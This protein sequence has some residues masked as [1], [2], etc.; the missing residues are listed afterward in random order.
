MSAAVS[1]SSQ[2]MARSVGPGRIRA[3]LRCV[4]CEVLLEE[5]AR[6]DAGR[7]HGGID[8]KCRAPR[9]PGAAVHAD[10]CELTVAGLEAKPI[11]ARVAGRGLDPCE[12]CIRDPAAT[13]RRSDVHALDLGEVS[14]HSDSPAADGST[15]DTRNEELDMW[16]KDRVEVESVALL[17]R[18]LSGETILELGDQAA[19]V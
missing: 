3:E 10:R 15:S 18:I 16:L 14:E 2:V 6:R 17:R 12:Q 19:H 8:A 5:H 1:S 7:R 11:E 13:C 9:E 4:G